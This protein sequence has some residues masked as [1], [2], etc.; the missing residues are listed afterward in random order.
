MPA[1]PQ[2]RRYKRTPSPSLSPPPVLPA[3]QRQHQRTDAVERVY[4]RATERV[5]NLQSYH[6]RQRSRES[7]QRA[8]MA[9][10]YREEPPRIEEFNPHPRQ[11]Q[12]QDSTVEYPQQKFVSE[13]TMMPQDSQI[14]D[15]IEPSP[16]G[17]QQQALSATFGA[18]SA[19]V[20][21]VARS[22]PASAVAK[23][24]FTPEE[25]NMLRQ[26]TFG[27]KSSK[28]ETFPLQLKLTPDAYK[29]K[30]NPGPTA[31]QSSSKVTDRSAPTPASGEQSTPRK[32]A[33]VAV[34][35]DGAANPAAQLPQ[36]VSQVVGA[37][38]PLPLLAKHV[39]EA[40]LSTAYT[41]CLQQEWLVARVF[42]QPQVLAS[43]QET[44]GDEDLTLQKCLASQRRALAHVSREKRVSK[45]RGV[46]AAAG[47]K[48]G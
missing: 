16:R 10:K 36:I 33:G 28:P 18:A 37:P 2:F 43:V 15:N 45:I 42:E 30:S 1:D 8:E 25:R 26:L 19:A 22:V 44:V 21:P 20:S 27:K 41:S 11:Q 7:E 3:P 47:N 24:Q 35:A 31:V 17:E 29:P 38:K 23:A 46:L 12:E 32:A 48:V 4:S 13:S 6:V 5:P 9:P 40:V 39:A 34:P 14:V